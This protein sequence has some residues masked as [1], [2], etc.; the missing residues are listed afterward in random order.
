MSGQS[1]N[2]LKFGPFELSIGS[3]L[4][5]NGTKIV[6]LGARAMD[7][8]IVL[9][10]QP[11][12]VVSKR[13]LIER[14]WP[15][16]GADEISL[17]VNISALR[18]ALAESDETCRYITNV[19]GRGYSFVV[20]MDSPALH[21]SE[22]EPASRPAL[23]A[24][25]MRMVGRK[26]AVGALQTKLVEQKFVTIVGPGG[27]G[28]TTVAVALAHEMRA[29]FDD[30]I[31]FVDLGPLGD[32]SLVTSA[33][34]M[35][36]GL[37]MQTGDILRALID[38]LQGAPTLLVLDGCEHLIGPVS[39]LAE[40]LLERAP[41]LH[42]LATS[43]EAMRVEGENVHELSALAYPPEGSA[44]SAEDALQYPAVQLLVDRVRA[45]R[46]QFELTGDNAPLAAKLCQRLD[47]IALAIELAACRVAVYDLAKTLSMLDDRLNLSW[48]GRRTALA[49]H[50]TLS[51][52]LDW[53]FGLLA[54]PERLVLK[55]LSVFR[56][57]FSLDAAVAVTADDRVDEASVSDCIWELRSKSLIANYSY[58]DVSRLRLLDTTHSFAAMLLAESGEQ[59][60]FRR[61][62]ALYF[63]DIFQHLASMDSSGW[64]RMLGVEVDNLRAALNWAF[65][66]EGDPN[67]GI[68]LAAASAS[69]WM[70]MGL[71]TECREWMTKAINRLDSTTA[72]TRSEMIIQ[73]A[74]ASCLMFTDGMTEESYGTWAKARLLARGVNDIESELTS[75]LVLWAHQIRIPNYTEAIKL[76][77]HCGE[78]SEALRERD[79]IAMANYMRGITY[80]HAGRISAAEAHLE[81]SLNRD[82]EV[83][84]LS[85]LKRFGWDRKVHALTILSNLVWLRGS[86]DQAR[87]LSRMALAEAR[88]LDQPVPLCDALTWA[89]F[90]SYLMTP[91]D[92]EAGVLANELVDYAGKCGIESYHGFG[93]S[94]QALC[95]MRR[96]E[97]EI[98]EPMICSGLEKLSA[99]RYGVFNALLQA[100]F[101]RCMAA[102]GRCREGLDMFD[103]AGIDLEQSHWCAPELNRI[104]GELALSNNEGPA[105]SKHYFLRAIELSAEQASLAWSLRAVTSLAMAERSANKTAARRTLKL[106][107]EK[108][109]EGLDTF[110]LR[111]ARQVLYGYDRRDDVAPDR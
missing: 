101:A 64:P 21:G 53:S 60:L 65:S 31:H 11:N 58:G 105:V 32:A 97:A 96:G 63:N 94:M 54:E 23:P 86:P 52:T 89:S 50:Q 109:K 6:P 72:G 83:S 24:R 40:K 100:E 46:G 87:R 74:L 4:L 102:A 78:V 70:G 66:T 28:K 73:S 38:R 76:A 33:V 49:R 37:G 61:R 77:D 42:L 98:A 27:I 103:H 59:Q 8:L 95:K 104:R 107:L 67:V 2:L 9:A 90:N 48:V 41:F 14:V 18:K 47:G 26:E 35:A 13:T 106:T 82:D 10:E 44:I 55:R 71:L 79:A 19:P 5:A 25:L 92:A 16:K 88:Q 7:L 43:R 111:L 12:K 36:F 56:G 108:Y 57:G 29:I 81:L 51:A 62:H 34:A 99:A 85:I 3:R 15:E 93:L 22:I 110:D 20:P 45:L 80:H 68:E 1:G 39:T 30:R 91:D 84:R 17:R 69:T 75:L